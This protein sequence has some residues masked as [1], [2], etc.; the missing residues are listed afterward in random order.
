MKQSD[1]PICPRCNRNDDVRK[2]LDDPAAAGEHVP[3]RDGYILE[4]IVIRAD[5]SDWYCASCSESFAAAR[6]NWGRFLSERMQ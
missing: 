2:I 1:A 4:G 3:V 5:S 6:L